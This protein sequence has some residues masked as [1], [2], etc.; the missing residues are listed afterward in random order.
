MSTDTTATLPPHG[1]LLVESGGHVDC[2]TALYV[3]LQDIGANGIFSD[4]GQSSQQE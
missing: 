1:C 4:G 2:H 3:V